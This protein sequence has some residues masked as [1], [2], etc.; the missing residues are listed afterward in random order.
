MRKFLSSALLA[1]AIGQTG[2]APTSA[3]ATVGKPPTSAEATFGQH[4]A[5]PAAQWFPD[6]ALGLFLHWD[7]ASVKG[8]NIGWCPPSTTPTS[9]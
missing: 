6:A 1:L 4:T 3:K 7:P 5:H 9:G 8:Q 2:Q